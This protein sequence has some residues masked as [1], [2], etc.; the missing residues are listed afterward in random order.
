[1]TFQV[2]SLVF[3]PAGGATVRAAVDTGTNNLTF[4]DATVTTPVDLS[5][6]NGLRTV[7][8]VLVVGT[9]GVGAQ[10]TT[11]QAAIDAVPVTATRSA[12]FLILV[13]PGTYSENLTINKDGVVILG[14]GL[15]TLTPA[16]DADTITLQAGV[17]T[18]PLYTR[19][20][21][22]RVVNSFASRACVR[23][24]GA[25]LSTLLN[26]ELLVQNCDLQATGAGSYQVRTSIVNNVRVRGGSWAGSSVTSLSLFEQTTSVR[27]LDV[28]RLS[29]LQLDYDTTGSLPSL[30]AGV[31]EIRRA[32]VAGNVQSTLSGGLLT[33]LLDS[34]YPAP[35]FDLDVTIFGDGSLEATRCRLGDLSINGAAAATTR[36]TTRQAAA[37]TGTLQESA[38]SGSEPFAAELTRVVSFDVAQPDTNYQVLPTSDNGVFVGVS[39]ETITGFTL[40]FAAPQTAT[41]KWRVVR[42]L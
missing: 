8:A 1:M 24:V 22:L 3:N 7:E 4:Q 41:V 2:D 23:V 28:E 12:P 30:P 10:Y 19:L 27:I 36:E 17:T 37:G 21:G 35:L 29:S 13:T 18:T 31:F 42:A 34:L 40:S 11:I 15:P 14:L 26:D 16:A 25:A 39:L 9:A 32:E 6:L 38:V 20:E 33:L 5:E